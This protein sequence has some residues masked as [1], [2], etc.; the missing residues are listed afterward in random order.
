MTTG[1]TTRFT[2]TEALIRA[3]QDAEA[4]SGNVETTLI[5]LRTNF[6]PGELATLAE[7]VKILD[8]CI[9]QVRRELA[10]GG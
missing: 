5:Y 3:M 9:E 7:A 10:S 6:L 1:Y 8:E 2:E 4:D